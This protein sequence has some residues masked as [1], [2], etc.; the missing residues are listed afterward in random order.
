MFI[1]NHNTRFTIPLYSHIGLHTLTL[2]GTLVLLLLHC[3]G[4][5]NVTNIMPV[6][7]T[8]HLYAYKCNKK[9]KNPTVFCFNTIQ[10]MTIKNLN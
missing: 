10:I 7:Y 2:N 8:V 6:L 3:Y 1:E 5:K 4:I 9:K